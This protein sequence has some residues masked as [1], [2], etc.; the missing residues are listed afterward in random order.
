MADYGLK[1]NSE[2]YAD[3]TAYKAITGIQKPGEIWSYKGGDA[4]IVNNHGT[5]SSILRL[6]EDDGAVFVAVGGRFTDPRMLSYAFNDKFGLYQGKITP[7]EWESVLDGIENALG[8]D[9]APR[10]AINA[11]NPQE[12]RNLQAELDALK[13]RLKDA[14]SLASAHLEMCATAENQATK[15]RSQLEMIKQMYSDLMEKFLQRA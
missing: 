14:E 8:V 15:Y 12:I 5:F 10:T 7:G 9:L 6:T 2:G 11:V 3:P 4:L 13:A 1:R